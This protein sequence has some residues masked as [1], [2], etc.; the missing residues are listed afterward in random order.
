MVAFSKSDTAPSQRLDDRIGRRERIFDTCC[1]V[2]ES[3]RFRTRRQDE[4]VAAGPDAASNL[5]VSQQ[6]NCASISEVDVRGWHLTDM[7]T[8][9]K[10]ACC[11]TVGSGLESWGRPRW[12][13][14]DAR[15]GM[16]L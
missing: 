1:P 13:R 10:L 8:N 11:G 2:C 12:S 3:C 16:L 14:L 9:A 15:H 7:H 5:N 6:L 4:E